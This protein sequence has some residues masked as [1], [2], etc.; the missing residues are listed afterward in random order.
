MSEIYYNEE[1][2]RVKATTQLLKGYISEVVWE[3]MQD[4]NFEQVTN[5]AF[6]KFFNSLKRIVCSEKLDN[7]QKVEK[8]L[9]LIDKYKLE[10]Y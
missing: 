8:I 9:R 1:E 7:A 2:F 3:T 5:Q 6:E 4:M 10:L